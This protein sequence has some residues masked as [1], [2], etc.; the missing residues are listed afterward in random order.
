VWTQSQ[1]DKLAEWV[2]VMGRNACSL[3]D[4]FHSEHTCRE[5]H[6]QL[7]AERLPASAIVSSDEEDEL[8]NIALQGTMRR[9]RKPKFKYASCM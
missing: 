8:Q 9:K 5:I 7:A 3:A 1:K 2:P 4:V 6:A